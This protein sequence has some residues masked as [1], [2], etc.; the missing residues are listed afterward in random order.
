M[1]ILLIICGMLVGSV[2]GAAASGSTGWLGASLGALIGFALAR[3]QKLRDRVA[4]L[5]RQVQALQHTMATQGTTGRVRDKAEAQ[6]APAAAA[7]VAAAVSVPAK[8]EQPVEPP[9][10]V[11]LAEPAPA[12]SLVV[13]AAPPMVE[14]APQAA[15]PQPVPP[16]PA[17][18]PQ[19]QPVPATP[20]RPLFDTAPQP[21]HDPGMRAFE[22]IKNWF[23]TGNV[24]MKVGAIVL[25]LGVAALLKYAADQGW[26][27]F[28]IEYRLAGVAAV[29]IAALA[30][31][32]R[33]RRNKPAFALS[34]QGIAIGILIL[35]VFAAFQLYHLL[36][37]TAA[38]GLL[39]VLVAGTGVLAVLQESVALAVFGCVAGFLAPILISTGVEAHVALFSYYA[40][41]NAAVFGVAWVRPW[42]ALNLLGFV[43]TFGIGTAWGVLQYK[44]EYFASTEPFLILF[45]AFY[46][47]IPVLYA[48]RQAPQ[49]R[50]LVDGTLVFG[51]PLLGFPLQAGLLHGDKIALAYSALV[52]AVVYALL[53]WRELKRADL[54]LLGESHALLALGFATLAVP[55]ALSARV[56]ACSWALEGAALVWLGLRQERKFP[57]LIGYLLQALAGA[58]FIVG[59][60]ETSTV[61]DRAILNGNFLGAALLF[62]AGLVTSRLLN[63][64]SGNSPLS[65]MFFLWALAWWLFG[66][67]MEIGRH[68]AADSLNWNI[69]LLAL[70]G[71]VYIEMASALAWP[72]CAWPALATVLIAFP[73]T[74]GGVSATRGPLEGYSLAVWIAWTATALR[75][76][77]RTQAWF[78]RLRVAAHLVF[79]GTLMLLLCLEIAHWTSD[80]LLLPGLWSALATLA[81]PAAV[82]WLA[83]LRRAPVRYPLGDAAETSRPVLLTGLALVM[84]LCAFGAL[85]GEGDPRPLP[86]VPVLN[87][88]EL[89]QGFFVLSM[90]AWYRKAKEEDSAIFDDRTRA[91]VLAFVGF[92]VLTSM[93]LRSVHFFTGAPWNSHLLDS[94]VAQAS[95]SVTWSVAGLAAMLI[96]ARKKSRAVWIGGAVLMAVVLGKLAL[97][98]RHHL[99][100]L[101]GIVSFLAVGM[102]LLVVGWYAPVPPREGAGETA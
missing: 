68:A 58:A 5:D 71:I 100:D 43:F 53:A 34:L 7:P 57:R 82:F 24:P 3:V 50:G 102:L 21:S 61:D 93:V 17:P 75:V 94:I 89:G 2:V 16:T 31:G 78:R 38:F 29:A 55:L 12:P 40:L 44:P 30:F 6:E 13:D 73:L 97:I 15:A 90:L 65:V 99:G 101:A 46:L 80:I 63:L 25:F 41:L 26:M 56:T 74:L 49:K 98:D 18:K 64:R 37:A 11:T 70:T 47:A 51:T 22:A 4:E 91:S 79:L 32:W 62:G 8:I 48:L 85:F 92:A 72:L 60:G 84:G 67:E 88:L 45:G 14:L 86:Y 87:P 69:F 81:V 95:L 10:I 54:R 83:L 77:V 39:V 42:R 96:G 20:S 35:T 28:P 66:A 52:V 27:H 19:P 76:L 23:T 36:P 59:F 1:T 33:Q 9:P